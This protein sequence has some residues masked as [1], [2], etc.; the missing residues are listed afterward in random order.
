MSFPAGPRP[1]RESNIA[2]CSG[3]GSRFPI[4]RFATVGN[5]RGRHAADV[6]LVR[7]RRSGQPR[8]CASGRRGRNRQ[9]A[10][11]HEP[12]PGLERRRSREAPGRDRSGRPRLVGQREHRRRRG[13]QDALRR[14]PR[15]NRQLQAIDPQHRARRR[16]DLLLQFHGPNRLDA[17]QS[18]LA[19]PEW[20]NGF[21][22]RRG[23][24]RR[25]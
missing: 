25:L 21:A 15:Q 9:R 14:L 18:Q 3:R 22:L 11:S 4:F 23:R 7:A 5:D 12:G 10:P 20:R 17:D 13:D 19:A 16:E 6:A 8:Q 24:F 1:D 2:T